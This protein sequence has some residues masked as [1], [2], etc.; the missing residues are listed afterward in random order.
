VAKVSIS[1][2]YSLSAGKKAWRSRSQAEQ[3]EVEHLDEVA[4][5]HTDHGSCTGRLAR[6]RDMGISEAR[7]GSG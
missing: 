4:A 7:C 3:E 1:E 2:A 6:C 5:G